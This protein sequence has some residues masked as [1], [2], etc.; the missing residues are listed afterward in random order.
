MVLDHISQSTRLFV[1]ASTLAYSQFLA[2]GDLDLF[3]GVT[4]PE[5]LKDGVAEAEHQDVLHGFFAQIMIDAEYLFLA[6]EACQLAVEAQGGCEV[7]SK[8]SFNDHALPS[9]TVAGA[10]VMQQTNAVQFARRLPKLARQ[11]GEVEKEVAP[12]RL[13]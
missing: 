6:G 5:P 7:V 12:E 4:C 11:S 1:V 2:D 8:R 13:V 10:V 9:V 3:D